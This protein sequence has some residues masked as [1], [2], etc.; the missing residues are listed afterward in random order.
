MDEKK[1][2]QELKNIFDKI[3]QAYRIRYGCLHKREVQLKKVGYDANRLLD[4]DMKKILGTCLSREKKLL[5]IARSEERYG[6]SILNY[7]K[8]RLKKAKSELQKKDASHFKLEVTQVSKFFQDMINLLEFMEKEIKKVEKRMS[9]EEKAIQSNKPEDIHEFM[10]EWLIEMKENE[11]IIEAYREVI[12]ENRSIL[13]NKKWKNLKK[14]PNTRES[15]LL[16]VGGAGTLAN[17]VI[18]VPLLLIGMGL[19]AG[20]QFLLRMQPIMNYEFVQNQADLKL[21]EKMR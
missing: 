3:L 1:E 4:P 6:V 19:Y 7:A 2:A 16:I 15:L 11:K 5:D 14:E 10:K 18:G 13:N 9:K 20:R 8:K 12:H 21:L 17:P